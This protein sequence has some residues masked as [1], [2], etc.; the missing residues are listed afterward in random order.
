MPAPLLVQGDSAMPAR[1]RKEEPESDEVAC[2]TLQHEDTRPL[3]CWYVRGSA[4]MWSRTRWSVRRHVGQRPLG[5]IR[6]P[7]LL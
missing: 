5:A 4:L 3:A 7:P 2:M 1:S 6:E